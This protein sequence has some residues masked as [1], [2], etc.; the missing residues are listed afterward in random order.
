MATIDCRE[1]PKEEEKD[2]AQVIVLSNL[3]KDF[4]ITCLVVRIKLI[5]FE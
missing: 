3:D 4:L 2:G 5:D 1:R